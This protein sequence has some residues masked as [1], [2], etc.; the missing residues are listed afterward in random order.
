MVNSVAEEDPFCINKKLVPV[1]TL[2]LPFVVV[3]YPLQ[4]PADLKSVLK[5]LIPE[6]ITA[7]FGSLTQVVDGILYRI[8]FR[9]ANSSARYLNGSSLTAPSLQ[10][11]KK[12]P[13]KP[14][15][16]INL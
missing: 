12:S 16:S 1:T 5:V 7:R 13:A 11:L 15:I 14:A 4:N 9:S 2:S 3:E 6:Y 8:T 10:E